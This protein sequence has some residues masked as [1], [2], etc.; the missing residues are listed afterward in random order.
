MKI[1]IF[2]WSK[3]RPLQLDACLRSIADNFINHG[4]IYVL[5]DFSNENF[6]NGYKKI[7][8]KSYNLNIMFIRQTIETFKKVNEEVLDLIKTEF[9]LGLCDDS[10]FIDKTDISEIIN[11]L[12]INNNISCISLRLGKNIKK[13]YVSKLEMKKPNFIE[14]NG[15]LCWDWRNSEGDWAYPFAV[16]TQIFNHDWYK[17]FVKKLDY[18]IP[19][20]LEGSFCSNPNSFGN[21]MISFENSK[22]SNICINRVQNYSNN[23]YDK[24]RDYNPEKL[25]NLFLNGFTINNEKIYKKSSEF[26]FQE[27]DLTFSRE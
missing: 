11:Y 10:M 3:D 27:I 9:S 17:N 12:K 8:E 1:D 14:E 26:L 13:H 24:T 23:L 18:N 7:F 15:Y 4:N 25:N 16:E 19:T 5:Y 20:T 22:I 2:I 21:L 6:Y